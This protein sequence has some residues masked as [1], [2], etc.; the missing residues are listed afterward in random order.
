MTTGNRYATAIAHL[1]ALN[2]ALA[3]TYQARMDQV[4]SPGD[5]AEL[6]VELEKALKSAAVQLD[7]ATRAELRDDLILNNMN[8]GVMVYT[9]GVV[10]VFNN[11]TGMHFPE[12]F[13]ADGIRDQTIR[14]LAAKG[15]AAYELSRE[16]IGGRA[17]VWVVI[18]ALL[19]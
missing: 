16:L 17:T 2:P 11:Y 6:T 14:R 3:A 9:Q 1:N 10:R 7:S 12:P 19:P 13:R 5:E 8:D 15:Y 4:Q 18:T